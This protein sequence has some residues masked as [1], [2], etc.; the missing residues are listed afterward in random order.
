[1]NK[2]LQKPITPIIIFT[3]LYLIGLLPFIDFK[4]DDAF[5]SYVYSKNLLI[6]NGLTYNGLM[7]EGYSNPLWTVLL[8][9]FVGFG[10]NPLTA[11]RIISILF[12]L[13]SCIFTFKLSKEIVP[14]DSQIPAILGTLSITVLSPFLAWSMGGLETIFFSSLIV[15]LVYLELLGTQ[16]MKHGSPVI[17]FLIAVTRPEGAMVSVIWLLYRIRM[18]TTK[19]KITLR[20]F[21]LFFILFSIF[22]GL[23][24]STYGYLLPN[25][26][27]RKVSPS[28]ANTLE[29]GK[30]LISFITLRPLFGIILLGGVSTILL[31]SS[32]LKQSALPFG[33]IISFIGFIL[34]SGRGWM[35][36]HRLLTPI[37]PLLAIPI[38]AL[39]K[40]PKRK[41]IKMIVAVITVLGIGIELYLANTLYKPLSIEFGN[42]TEGLIQAGKWI[43]ENTDSED[44]IAVVDAGALA[45]YAERPTID[46]IGL[47]NEVIAHSPNK[48]DLDYVLDFNPA[49]IQLHVAFSDTGIL[50]PPTDSDHNLLMIEH[51]IFKECY[52]PDPRRPENSF[53]PYLFLRNC[54]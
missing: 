43:R 1:M 38:T 2:F 29:A 49:V 41:L 44:I 54:K 39:Y 31:D 6:G 17:L 10:I 52:L 18:Q 27:Y 21:L 48:M 20:E 33:I 36:H 47:N 26:A 46:I 15:A 7:V 5:I 8:V 53:Y 3:V 25:T 40:I 13:L 50:N 9:P 16:S 30:W 28:L 23:R 12:A 51:P 11:S 45:Y 32:M 37:I 24:Y 19:L 35:P 22:L 42:F 4:V 14:L 34:I